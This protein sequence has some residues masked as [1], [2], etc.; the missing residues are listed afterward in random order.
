MNVR[1]SQSV[2]LLLDL[3]SCPLTHG[4]SCRSSCL[5]S[6]CKRNVCM[7]VCLSVSLSVCLSVCLPVCMSVCLYVC[8]YDIYVQ[9]MSVY[10]IDWLLSQIWITP[11]AEK[12]RLSV[13]LE[14]T[15]FCSVRRLSV[16]VCLYVCLSVCLSRLCSL[17]ATARSVRLGVLQVF[18]P[19]GTRFSLNSWRS[20][21]EIVDGYFILRMAQYCRVLLICDKYCII[22]DDR[23][24]FSFGVNWLVFE[25]IKYRRN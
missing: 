3:L 20:N 9:Y 8:L 14:P 23:L 24:V 16:Y 22:K 17:Y 10:V 18:T 7:S 25:E 21:Y 12:N 13:G 6:V 1:I 15:T 5:S 4:C 11:Q 19:S 2:S